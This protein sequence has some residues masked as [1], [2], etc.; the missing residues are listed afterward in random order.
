M[1]KPQ[2]PIWLWDIA[3]DSNTDQKYHVSRTADFNWKTWYFVEIKDFSSKEEAISDGAIYLS[4]C[5]ITADDGH[6]N[7]KYQ[8]SR[9]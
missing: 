8:V 7:E 4:E 9:T 2:F 5:M 1:Q 6:K 3:C